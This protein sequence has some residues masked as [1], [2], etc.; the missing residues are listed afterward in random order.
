[1]KK[2]EMAVSGKLFLPQYGK[3]FFGHAVSSSF[4]GTVTRI[5]R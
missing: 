3:D 5:F 2:P 1:M 4:N